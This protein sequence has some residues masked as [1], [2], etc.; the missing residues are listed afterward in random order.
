[1]SA[2]R[3]HE[4]RKFLIAISVL[5]V[6]LIVIVIV[7]TSLDSIE[8]INRE[9]EKEEERVT[10]QL[11]DYMKTSLNEVA[12]TGSDPELMEGILNPELMVSTDVRDQLRM[13][14][15]LTEIQRAQ[16]A[17]DYMTYV[18]SGMVLSS[19]TKEG[20]E[21]T[22]FPTEMPVEEYEVIEELGGKQG[23]FIVVFQSTEL[24]PLA[25]DEFVSIAVDRTEQFEVMEDF[26]AGE[27][28]DLITRQI[29]IGIVAVVIAALLTTLGV[30]FLTRRYITAPIEKLAAD[31][32]SIMEGSFQG[33]VEVVEESDYADIQ[34]LLQSG[35][36]LMEKMEEAQSGD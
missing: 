5:V 16:F 20:L 21:I 10:L 33:Q 25:E 7:F 8:R 31:S 36:V 14:Q 18:S 22:E 11:V 27:K 13:L 12:A 29:I 35:K 17:A 1:M 15:F 32:H 28:S 19:S 30:Y 26:Y 34:R 23:T 3:G 2:R 6:L 9:M 4:M 24:S